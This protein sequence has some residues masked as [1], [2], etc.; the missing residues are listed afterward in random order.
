MTKR[1]LLL[2]GSRRFPARTPAHVRMHAPAQKRTILAGW[3][4][5]TFGAGSKPG[6]LLPILWGTRAVT[7]TPLPP[8]AYIC[9]TSEDLTV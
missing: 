8:S 6:L 3:L 7:S 4:A 2:E 5:P 1:K 9:S